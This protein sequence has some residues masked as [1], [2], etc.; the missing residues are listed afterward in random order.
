MSD[1]R[2][3]GV[4]SAVWEPPA[5]EGASAPFLVRWHYAFLA[6]F[7]GIAAWV[8]GGPWLDH[9]PVEARRC[10]GI[11]TLCSLLWTTSLIPLQITSLIAL[12]LLPLTGV[13]KVDQAFALFGNQA[14]FFIIGAFILSAIVVMSGLSMRITCAVLN[15]FAGSPR[16]LR[17]GIFW[18]GAF[19]SFWM[20][21][22]AVAA[23]LFPIVM[24]MVKAYGLKPHES[25]FA[26]SFFF[27]LAWGCVIGGIATYLG[28]ARNLLA[29]AILGQETGMGISFLRWMKF[30][31]PLVVPMLLIGQFVL[32]ALYPPEHVSAGAARAVI[33]ERRRALGPMGGRER[34]VALVA[35]LTILTWIVFSS[36]SHHGGADLASISLMAIAVMF[37]F[38][39]A[40][41]TEVESEVNWGV[42]LMYG[43]AIALGAALNRTGAAKLLVDG[44][45]G[46]AVLPDWFLISFFAV[47][48]F[49]LT[50][51]I[52]NS[53]VVSVLLP[54]GFEIA[55][56]N[57]ISPELMTLAIALPSGLDYVLPM[58]TPATAI[59]YSSGYMTM[60]D[61]L[62]AGGL[63]WLLSVVCFLLIAFLVWPHLGPRPPPLPPGLP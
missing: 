20:S 53:A 19:A 35:A 29:V 15:R 45:L 28:G 42:I 37:I 6:L 2:P 58:G 43:G 31:L 51:F 4:D 59:A 5:S 1:H 9:W 50:G 41:W 7:I 30:S 23:M 13:M 34:K 57:G 26:K 44:A 21:E 36:E 62:R 47:A 25:G 40:K 10:F 12:G 17:N 22:H 11:F 33:E 63:M 38:R 52:S 24:G 55:R 54:V 18:F 16:L 61:F 39:L 48:S 60:R 49:I 46:D 8:G 32:E 14:T 3:A 56:R 27:A